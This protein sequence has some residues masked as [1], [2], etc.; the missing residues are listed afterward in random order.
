SPVA[1]PA[2][3]GALALPAAKASP[4]IPALTITRPVERTGDQRPFDFRKFMEFRK[5]ADAFMRQEGVAVLLRDAGK[6]HSLLNMTGT[7]ESMS[8]IP[9]L[10]VAHEHVAMLQRLLARKIPVTI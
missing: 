6:P 10:F 3:G 1:D 5:K 2:T 8:P 9:T 4:P 7:W